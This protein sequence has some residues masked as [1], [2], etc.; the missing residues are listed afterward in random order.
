MLATNVTDSLDR[1]ELMLDIVGSSLA[2]VGKKL[3]K[4][5]LMM[6]NEPMEDAESR[7][8]LMWQHNLDRLLHHDVTKRL[9]TLREVKIARYQKEKSLANKKTGKFTK[10]I[11]LKLSKCNGLSRYKIN[12][13]A[14]KSEAPKIWTFYE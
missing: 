11:S 9:P 8:K 10:R 12:D 4:L 6:H 5:E 7:E 2:K 1:Q 14:G 13:S 3:H